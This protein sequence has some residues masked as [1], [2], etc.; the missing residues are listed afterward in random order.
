[1]AKPTK[2]Q[3]RKAKLKAKKQQAIHNQQ[4]LTERLSIALEKLCEP[5][6]PEYIDEHVSRLSD[7]TVFEVAAYMALGFGIV[8]AL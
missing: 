1:M 5:V 8:K 4:S 3:K 2:E 6:L 7:D